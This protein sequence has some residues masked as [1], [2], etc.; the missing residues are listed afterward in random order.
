VCQNRTVSV[1]PIEVKRSAM[2]IAVL[3]CVVTHKLAS[4]LIA[5][6]AR[7]IDPGNR[8]RRVALLQQEAVELEGIGVDADDASSLVDPAGSDSLGAGAGNI[9][10]LNVSYLSLT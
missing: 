1:E 3:V 6:T 2:L 7:E 4:S 8:C 5:R 9:D 10:D